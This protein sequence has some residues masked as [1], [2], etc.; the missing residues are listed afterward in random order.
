M[1]SNKELK[2]FGY[3][4]EMFWDI[5]PATIIQLGTYAGGTAVWMADTL[6]KLDIKCHAYSMDIDLSMISDHAKC[7]S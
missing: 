6:S 2:R 5:H 4:Q 1:P 7:Y 3:L